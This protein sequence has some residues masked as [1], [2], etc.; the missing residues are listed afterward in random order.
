MNDYST[1]VKHQ[2]EVRSIRSCFFVNWREVLLSI[3]KKRKAKWFYERSHWRRLPLLGPVQT[4]HFTFRMELFEQVMG[5][6]FELFSKKKIA[7]M[8]VFFV[9]LSVGIYVTDLPR[10]RF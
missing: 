6:S 8:S 4:L 9:S 3:E 2:A 10:R 7:H 1:D 5:S